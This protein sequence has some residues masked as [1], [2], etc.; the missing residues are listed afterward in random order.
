MTQITTHTHTRARTQHVLEQPGAV[1]LAHPG[2]FLRHLGL[3]P[4]R[5][6][7]DLHGNLRQDVSPPARPLVVQDLQVAFSTL[8]V[9]VPLRSGM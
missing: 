9:D 4:E 2:G 5:R 3:I 7:V 6:V 8:P 1:R